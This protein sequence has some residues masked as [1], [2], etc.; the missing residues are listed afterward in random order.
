MK[1][2]N[3]AAIIAIPKQPYIDW[4]NALDDDGPRMNVEEHHGEDTVYLVDDVGDD[5]D[6]SE[7]VRRYYSVI[8]EQ[9]LADWHTFESAWPGNRD[10]QTFT[11]WFHIQ[12][13]SVVLDLCNYRVK[14][15]KW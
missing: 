1:M 2:I 12:V 15:E 10:F 13:N 4:A 9:E 8:F 3:R 11:E 14:S 6:T 7:V 5:E